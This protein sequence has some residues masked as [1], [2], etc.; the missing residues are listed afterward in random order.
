[1]LCGWWGNTFAL[2]E[3]VLL[4]RIM[5]VTASEAINHGASSPTDAMVFRTY[6]SLMLLMMN[7]MT[8]GS[9]IFLKDFIIQ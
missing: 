8:L 7:I 6:R 9:L 3:T 5:T 4:S 1:M 2:D